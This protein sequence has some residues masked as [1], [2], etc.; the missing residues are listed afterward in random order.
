MIQHYFRNKEALLLF[1]KTRL[2]DQ[3]FER[4]RSAAAREKGKFR[5]Y[6]M[7]MELMPLTAADVEMYKV[8]SAFRGRAIGNSSL[9]DL[10]RRRER[11][12]WD[13]FAQEI[14]ALKATGEIVPNGDSERAAIG[15]VAFI[16]GL[17]LPLVMGSRVPDTETLLQLFKEYFEAAFGPL[18]Q[19]Y[20]VRRLASRHRSPRRGATARRRDGANHGT[21]VNVRRDGHRDV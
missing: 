3:K 4:M 5:L 13:M 12:G 16:E 9:M 7:A 11:M 6:A 20:N 14:A 8:L 18:P 1:A 10:Q 19:K 21:T 17:A 15:L 2:V